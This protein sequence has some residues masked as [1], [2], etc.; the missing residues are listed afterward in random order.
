MQVVYE[1]TD[2]SYTVGVVVG[3][4]LFRCY[5]DLEPVMRRTVQ[6]RFDDTDRYGYGARVESLFVDDRH[7]TM[8]ILFGS[9][10]SALTKHAR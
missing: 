1:N 2:G 4:G 8:G 5:E 6:V 3:Y 7:L 9:Q 10:V